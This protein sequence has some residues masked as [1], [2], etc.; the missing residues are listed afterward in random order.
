MSKST[1]VAKRGVVVLV[2]NGFAP[3]KGAGGGN[4]T[5]CWQNKGWRLCF[6][7]IQ[8]CERWKSTPCFTTRGGGA[9]FKPS[10]GAGGGN[11][12]LVSQQGVVVLVL[13]HPREQE[14]EIHPPLAKRGVVA[15][16]RA[17]QRCK[18]WTGKTARPCT[19]ADSRSARNGWAL[20]GSPLLGLPLYA[21]PPCMLLP[22]MLLPHCPAP[23]RW[24][25]TALLGLDGR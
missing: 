17:I 12:P 2:S 25:G 11:A 13:R 19:T 5:P 6:R 4:S 21:F 7:A 18:R 14:V 22:C 3:S 9:G 1:P 20:C 15:R 8:S 23:G 16:F 24:P 10:K